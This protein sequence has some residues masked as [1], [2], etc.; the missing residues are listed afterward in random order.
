MPAA[1]LAFFVALLLALAA[2]P[3]VTPSFLFFL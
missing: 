3:L 1:L 2:S